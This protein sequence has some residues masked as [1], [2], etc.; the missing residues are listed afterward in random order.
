MHGKKTAVKWPSSASNWTRLLRLALICGMCTLALG[1]SM[2]GT[3]RTVAAPAMPAL[4]P[5]LLELLNPMQKADAN[6][7]VPCPPLLPEAKSD[8]VDTLTR[9]HIESAGMYHDCAVKQTGLGAYLK[10]RDAEEA[11][12]I[13]RAR[14]ALERKR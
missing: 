9:N 2:F 5:E 8:D 13:E 1:C 10:Q 14:Q 7:M 12:R 3:K 6:L 11:A 4:P